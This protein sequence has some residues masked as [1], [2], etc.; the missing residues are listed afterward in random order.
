MAKYGLGVTLTIPVFLAGALWYFQRRLIY[1]ADFPEGSRTMVPKPTEA[2][3]PYEDVTLT[4][5]DGLRIKAFM[6]PARQ[7]VVP[8]HELRGLNNMVSGVIIENTFVSL[9]SLVPH[10]MPVPPFLVNLLLSE[11]WDAAKA[12]PKIPKSTPI[13]FLSGRRDE[14]VPQ[15]Q[16]LALR[17]LRLRQGGKC[18][19]R[20][21]PHGTHNDTYVAPA[22]WDEIG[23]WLREEIEGGEKDKVME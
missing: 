20:E 7:R 19:W 1:P 3:L 12:L 15:A 9:E 23:V 18:C 4:T 16:M 13:L 2:A 14:L 6:I 10:V 21:F 5:P 22:Y 17:E 11:R 8:L